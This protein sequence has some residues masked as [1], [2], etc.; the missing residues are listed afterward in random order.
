MAIAYADHLLPPNAT[1]LEQVISAVG[2][3]VQDVPVPIDLLKRPLEV[4]E[5]F[6]PA[7]AFELSVDEWKPGWSL[8]RR[9]AITA[10]S[11]LLHQKKGTAYTLREYAR[12]ADGNVLKIERPPMRVFSGASLT[13]AQRESWLASLPQIR[14]WRV[15]E[16]GVAPSHKAFLGGRSNLRQRSA[17]F[18]FSGVATTPSVAIQHLQRRARW[19]VGGVETDTRVSNEGSTLRLHI[20]GQAGLKVFSHRPIGRRYF[21]VSDAW[22]RIV[23]VA[24][25][26][27][28]PWR[29]A[30]VPTLQAV[31]SEPERV[32]VAGMRGCSVFSDVPITGRA[33]FVPSSAA[34]RIYERYPV[35][36]PDTTPRRP[37][38]QFMGTGRYGFPVHAARVHLSAPGKRSPFAAGDGVF[39]PRHRF[40]MPHDPARLREARLGIRASMRLS[41]KIL[42]RIGPVPRFV[43]GGAPFFA[44]LDKL[45][46]GQP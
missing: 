9:R 14:L 3:R 36:L 27:V 8:T 45:V 28:L 5:P 40:W 24:P 25:T 35:L 33:F 41:D 46:V 44:D 18:F 7:L 34:L 10:A 6:L 37:A 4:P 17:R 11:I 39:V 22:K 23:T 21:V 32:K 31:E 15:R 38:V 19:V 16:Q 42:L 13:R 29:S 12:Y 2:T 1:A 43:A 30:L 20:K 26:A